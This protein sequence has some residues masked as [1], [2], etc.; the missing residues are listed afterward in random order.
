MTELERP[1]PTPSGSVLDIQRVRTVMVHRF[2]EEQPQ[3]NQP[4]QDTIPGESSGEQ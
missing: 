1:I 4:A 3:V 2:R